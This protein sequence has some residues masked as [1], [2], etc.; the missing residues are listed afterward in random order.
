MKRKHGSEKFP[1]IESK[2]RS[3]EYT[4]RLPADTKKHKATTWKTMRYVYDECEQIIP[5]FYFCSK[6]QMIFNLIL[7][8]S[9]KCLKLHVD[10]NC[11]GREAGIDA[12]FAPEYQPVKKRK[13]AVDD[14]MSVRDAAIAFVVQDMRP[15]NSL[16]GEGMTSLLSKMTFIGA[17]YGALTE[18]AIAE[19]KIIPSR[20]TV[21]ALIW[22]SLKG[23]S[24]KTVDYFTDYAAHWR[25]SRKSS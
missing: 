22:F 25:K 9:G 23:H 15:I 2:I 16:N 7:R 21:S 4:C 18:E 8:D 3:G 6:C 17:K 13:I 20:Q 12:F 24:I 1:E 11:Y 19:L 5:D 10:N 14:K